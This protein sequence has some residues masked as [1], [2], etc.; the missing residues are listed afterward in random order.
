[1]DMGRKNNWITLSVACIYLVLVLIIW[2]PFGPFQG[3]PY[4]THFVYS[5]ETSS[6]LSGFIYGGDP[7]KPHTSTFYHL[8]Y[9]L[10]QIIGMEG[11]FLPYQIIYVLLWWARGI[12]VFLIVRRFLP[13]NPFFAYL[14]GALVIA[15]AVDGSLMWVG[16]LNQ[17]GFIFWMLLAFYMLILTFQD[18]RLTR[19]IPLLALMLFFQHMSLWSYESQLFIMLVAPFALLLI[20]KKPSPR[21]LVIAGLWYSHANHLYFSS[22]VALLAFRRTKL[23]GKRYASRFLGSFTFE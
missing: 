20:S 10:G 15:H 6:L 16:Q 17:F 9:L 23:P 19:T 14:V 12:L 1:M 13:E 4:E 3:M 2:L 7:L 21:F 5:S 18:S 8:S 11:S 22:G